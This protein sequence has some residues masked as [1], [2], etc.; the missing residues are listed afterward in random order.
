MNVFVV[1]WMLCVNYYVVLIVIG[2]KMR[3]CG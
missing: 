3:L 2:D 1:N